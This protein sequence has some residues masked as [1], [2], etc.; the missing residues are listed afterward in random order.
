MMN[1]LSGLG[2]ADDDGAKIQ[3]LLD[4]GRI[5]GRYWVDLRKG[6][7]ARCCLNTL[8]VVDVCLSAEL[9]ERL[10][11]DGQTLPCERLARVQRVQPRRHWYPWIPKLRRHPP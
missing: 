1:V 4:C 9:Y 10:T 5:D 3:Q 7:I 2:L 8:D 11:L 6:S